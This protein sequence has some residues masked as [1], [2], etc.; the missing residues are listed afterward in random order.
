MP[1]Q[2]SVNLSEQLRHDFY[3]LATRQQWS[4]CD[5]SDTRHLNVV[6]D[7]HELVKQAQWQVRIFQAVDGQST[8]RLF[9][10]ILH[11]HTMVSIHTINNGK[12]AHHYRLCL[13]NKL[14]ESNLYNSSNK[15]W[16]VTMK[17]KTVVTICL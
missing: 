10:T 14:T 13:M 7:W 8:A 12:L 2:P 9:V 1:A 11:Q 15:W 6:D 3:L 17:N 4:K 16:W 5:A